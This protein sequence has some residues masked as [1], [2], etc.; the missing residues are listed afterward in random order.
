MAN[1]HIPVGSFASLP[2]S[3]TARE[4]RANWPQIEGYTASPAEP[5]WVDGVL[6][7]AGYV[8]HTNQDP[9][10]DAAAIIADAIALADGTTDPEPFGVSI[11][12]VN[13]QADLPAQ[14]P[15]WP[16][17]RALLVG[18]ASPPGL[19]AWARGAWRGPF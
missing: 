4:L 5:I 15:D 3:K 17:D 14:P 18:V 16:D 7:G 2:T 9:E 19:W 8:I 6:L 13:T 1:L 12:L 11:P 10:P